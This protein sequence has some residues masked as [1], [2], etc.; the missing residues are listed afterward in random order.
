M[1]TRFPRLTGRLLWPS[2]AFRVGGNPGR[3]DGRSRQPG[4][5]TLLAPWPRLRSLLPC[6]TGRGQTVGAG[7]QDRAR[8]PR[9][10]T[11]PR[12]FPCRRPSMGSLA[13]PS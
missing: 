11:F 7:V 5:G 12:A 10:F 4:S 6:L 2:E 8:L 9:V 1:G 13:T 3:V